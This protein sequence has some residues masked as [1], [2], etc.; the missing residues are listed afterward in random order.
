MIDPNKLGWP[1]LEPP[2]GGLARMKAR[3]QPEPLANS[4]PWSGVLVSFSLS[5]MLMVMLILPWRQS[6]QVE[7][8][9][10]V[11]LDRPSAKVQI[12]DGAAL[13][14]PIPVPQTRHYLVMQR[15]P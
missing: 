8:A 13:E 2:I 14:R 3:L 7:A 5:T 1:I 4:P 11:V 10:G 12:A 9:L 6:N 15:E